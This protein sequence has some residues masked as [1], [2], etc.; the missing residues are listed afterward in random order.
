MSDEL[1]NYEKGL[2]NWFTSKQLCNREYNK[3]VFVSTKIR[4]LIMTG[5]N[6]GRLT[7]DGVVKMYVF[8]SVGGGVYKVMTQRII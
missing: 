1:I 7:I 5:D 4:K 2:F 8:K 3:Q 6:Q